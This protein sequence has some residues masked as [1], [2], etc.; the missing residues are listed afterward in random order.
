M[1]GFGGYGDLGGVC[2]CGL[3][4]AGVLNLPAIDVFLLGKNLLAGCSLPG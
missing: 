3:G 4:D 2:V 1:G